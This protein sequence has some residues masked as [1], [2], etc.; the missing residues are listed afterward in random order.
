[1]VERQR[2]GRAPS[3]ARARPKAARDGKGPGGSS[4]PRTGRDLARQVLARVEQDGAFA[5]RALAAALDRATDL[6]G[7]D[8]ALA[9][10]LVYGVL[11]RRAR[12]DSALEGVADRGITSLE[13]AMR[14]LLR[15]GAYQIL[16]LDRV[17]AYAAVHETV[18]AAKRA[19]GSR[20]AGLTNAL[21]RRVAERGEPALPDP[22]GD[23]LGYLRR[24]CG[25]PDWLARLAVRDIGADTAIALG[26][27]MGTPAPLSMRANRL[28][29][30][31]RD[32]LQAVIVAE[33]PDA[34]LIPSEAAPDAL[35]GHGFDA[36]ARSQAFLDGAFAIQDVG[37]QLVAE[38]CGAAPGDRVLDACA[39]MGG[40]TAHLAA[41]GANR[42]S[43][44]ALDL[45]A[46]KLGQASREC[47]RL[48]VKGV[49]TR[50]VDLTKDLA[51]DHGPY[52]RV[53]LDA[54]CAGLGVLRR[55]PETLLR[56][57]EADLALLAE[58][59]KRMLDVVAPAVVPGGLLVYAVC[60]FDRVEGEDV[61][62]SFLAAHPEF[63]VEPP[64]A[65][66]GGVPWD[67]VIDA[68]GFMRTWPHRDGADAFFAARLRRAVRVQP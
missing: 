15:V 35:V 29:G 13:P 60:T 18:E 57:T 14:I 17:P 68:N 64:V 28:V 30:V 49:R 16:F 5:S 53:L 43:I 20:L 61:V 11:R 55:H 46:P 8:R 42:V 24:A 12:L 31:T 37:A 1:L 2:G 27:E 45:S 7:S 54:P 34:M 21:L 58:I 33:H 67:R 10:E 66:A 36:P 65:S 4:P 48:G 9:T 59:Q 22:K 51:L 63:H 38:L 23:P 41:L 56:R 44:D 26:T 50:T 40:K 19:H 25:F 47:D 3:Q 62:R 52:D 39:G 32:Q 6:G